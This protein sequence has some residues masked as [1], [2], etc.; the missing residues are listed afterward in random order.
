MTNHFDSKSGEQNIAQGD[1]AT[2]KTI[3]VTHTV[4]GDGNISSGTGNV[5]VNQGIPHEV[6]AQYVKELGA[7]EQ[8]VEGF[9][10]TLLKEKVPR[11]Q[12]DSKLREI[13][14]TYKELLARVGDD[15]AA[16]QAIEA[17]DYA[18]AEALLED[19]ANQHSLAAA[20]AHADNARLQRIQL[21]YAKAAAYW[22]KAAALLPEDK[23]KDRSLYL[24][25]AGYDLYRI[26][27]CAEALPLFE[28]SL[29]IR[30]EIGDKAG[31]GRIL[32]N[33]S[34]VYSARGDYDTTLK[35]L[36]QSLRISQELVDKTG[37]GAILGNIGVIHHAKGE[38]AVALKYLEQS[39]RI[40]QETGDRA[41]EGV[42]LN[43]ISQI[44]KAR[45]EYFTSLK[46][47]EQSLRISQELGDK[48]QEGV[49]LN[50][51]ATTAYTNGDYPA[52]LKYLEQSLV[53]S[54][55]IG[56]RAGEAVTSWNIGHAYAMQGDLAKAEQYMSRAVQ[57]AEEIGHP[58]LKEWR[59]A[60]KAVRAK[61]KAQ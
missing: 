49:T 51:I 30:Q 53:I 19:V 35:Y 46:Y 23:K 55:E 24:N 42:T 22:Q 1:G 58:K 25:N 61:I 34:Q 11:D 5:T 54:Q 28:H 26:T 36:E 48:K 2:G 27:H 60:L 43:N 12:W 21:R 18:K 40:S 32:N 47:L 17:G 20:K 50:N 56:N 38:Y 39:L 14:A 15:Q 41:G 8:V 52:V 7:T 33:I 29:V 6:F 31:E 9:F 10:G 45:S 13:A 57:L 59:K 3:N 37:E 16:K 44:Y 4:N